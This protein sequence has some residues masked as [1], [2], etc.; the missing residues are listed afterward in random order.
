MKLKPPAYLMLGMLRL[1]ATSGYAIKKATDVS[2][3]F[4]WPTSLAQVY[5]ELSRL[6][7]EGLVTRRDDP[8]GA[9]ARSAYEI[10]AEGE[11]ALLAWLRSTR[12]APL[13][14]R[15]EGV[16]RLFFADALSKQ[17]QLALVQGLRKRA[18]SAET[19]MRGEIIPLG[20][21]L[22]QA[23]TRFPVAVARLGADLYAYAEQW[24]A[25]LEKKLS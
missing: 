7:R 17:D 15:D 23:G 2:T 10:T 19:Y 6:E 21:P 16:L 11:A 3:R 14:F 25:E 12:S 8:Q 24:L 4:F 18:K 13:Q 5:P 1:G 9:R 20:E 22:E